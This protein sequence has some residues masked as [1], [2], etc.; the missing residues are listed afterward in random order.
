MIGCWLG[1]LYA[2]KKKKARETPASF[3]E[4]VLGDAFTTLMSVLR[5][6]LT[7]HHAHNLSLARRVPPCVAAILPP[8]LRKVVHATQG[9]SAAGQFAP[10]AAV[11]QTARSDAY[12]FATVLW[13]C[14]SGKLPF[15]RPLWD[16]Y[17][18]VLD[19][20]RPDMSEVRWTDGLQ[21]SEFAAR[22]EALMRDG[23]SDDASRRPTLLEYLEAIERLLQGRVVALPVELV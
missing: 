13:E 19:G 16:V 6:R 20:E 15:E 18:A 3:G 7:R 12:S 2:R 17:A 11:P 21:D 14:L 22:L 23:W 1:Y 10:G 8:H 9:G 4:D 5:K